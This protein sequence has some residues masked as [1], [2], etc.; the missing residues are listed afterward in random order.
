[1]GGG[2]ARVARAKL[3]RLHPPDF[4]IGSIFRQGG[5]MRF[6]QP[7]LMVSLLILPV[8]ALLWF[9]HWKAK[10]GFRGHAGYDGG[11]LQALSR[12]STGG[13]DLA[14]L[15]AALLA[16][17]ALGL[18][19]M[20]PQLYLD[21]MLPQYEQQDLVLILD[22]SVSMNARDVPPSRFARAVDELRSFLAEKPGE[23][24]RVSLV[25]FAGASIVLS[26][27]TR[28]LE[29]LF[30]FLDWILEDPEI[31]YGTDIAEALTTALEVTK[32]DDKATR[33]IF[34]LLS[35]GDDQSQK[36][37]ALLT[38]LQG[39]GI[40]VH[41]IGIGSEN[42]VPMPVMHA[43]GDTEYL[44][45]EEGNQLTTQF[46]ESTLR[47]V[48]SM[49]GGSFFRSTT[50]HELGGFMQEVLAQEQRQTGWQRSVDYLD[51]HVPLLLL[52]CLATFFLAVK[53]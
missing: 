24:D 42:A 1:M 16:S 9:L 31:Y 18:A 7:D 12:Q 51:M 22:R 20:R 13:R 49:T 32:K 19:L 29:A 41:S 47:M 35:D 37:T 4:A 27:L 11:M 36:L 43:G 8:L 3:R 23:I 14:V 44:E 45:D 33:K 34:L 10:Y 50:G 30:F 26:H 46:D 15:A 28:D 40:R 6:L 21:R 2:Y 48:A 17:A 5:R 39:Q 38:E 52:A 53:I 25:G